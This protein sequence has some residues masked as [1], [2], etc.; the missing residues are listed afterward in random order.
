MRILL[1]MVTLLWGGV[2]FAEPVCH[3]WRERLNSLPETADEF[4][5]VIA[6]GAVSAEH[7]ELGASFVCYNVHGPD[8]ALT[9]I[10]FGNTL[11]IEGLKFADFSAKRASFDGSQW[12]LADVTTP[13]FKATQLTVG[14]DCAFEGFA[15]SRVVASHVGIDGV[16]EVSVEGLPTFANQVNQPSGGFVPP[17]VR[18][19]DQVEVAASGFVLGWLGVG[20]NV[21]PNEYTGGHLLAVTDGT[22]VLE[23]GA[24]AL[25]D[26]VKGHAI[27]EANIDNLVSSSLEWGPHELLQP[28]ELETG[29]FYRHDQRSQIGA[30]IRGLDHAATTSIDSRAGEDLDTVWRG[31]LLFGND[32]E[33]GGV[34]ISTD[35]IHRSEWHTRQINDETQSVHGSALGLRVSHRMGDGIFVEPAVDMAMTFGVVPTEDGYQAST[36]ATVVPNLVIGS[37]LVGRFESIEH[38]IAVTVRGG[39][40]VYGFTQ[41]EPLPPRTLDFLYQRE[42]D[43]LVLQGQLV[44]SL[45]TRSLQLVWPIGVE[46]RADDF[47]AWT[48]LGVHTDAIS[49]DMR[50]G[51]DDSC[52]EPTY[53]GEVGLSRGGL[54][55]QLAGGRADARRLASWTGRGPLNLT[56]IEP[57]TSLGR[58][59]T[60]STSYQLNHMLAGIQG[61]LGQERKA[62]TAFAM[63]QFALGWNL[64]ARV[65]YDFTENAV[66][67][68][69]GVGYS[70][71]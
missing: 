67:V 43:L 51:C 35:L 40:E 63:W 17:V 32:A 53:L 58:A 4:A 70:S 64:G 47:W 18:V 9:R 31:Q 41:R 11:K 55:I 34:T 37:S 15:S 46:Y 6:A 50:G 16:S 71:Q 69:A 21:A 54:G 30:S 10:E 14:S 8:W 27:G 7:C 33:V 66:A 36:T 48:G 19:A 68:M 28:R 52:E 57:S 29:A 38:R 24:V 61:V 49:A 5:S 62:S 59:A 25:D 1:T 42:S 60:L 3:D 13:T 2:L 22:R 26:Q 23:V 12:L 20:V 44:Q 45:E 56:L 39:A 65:G